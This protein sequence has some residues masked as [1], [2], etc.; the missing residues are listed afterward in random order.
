MNSFIKT[1]GK[2]W[3]DGQYLE[4]EDANIPVLTHGLHYA[5]CVYEGERSYR[6]KVF[7]IK[8]HIA[9]LFK[10]AEIMDMEIPYTSEELEIATKEVIAT[11]QLEDA[12][13]RPVVWR[14]SDSIA[15]FA[16]DN[17]IHTAICAWQW[18]SYYTKEKKLEGIRMCV[19]NWRRPDPQSA[20]IEAKASG[21]YM[22]LTLSKH[23][24]MRKGFDDALLLDLNGAVAEASSANIFFCS[25]NELHTPK[26]DNILNG[27]TRQTV[28]ELAAKRQ[29]KIVEREILLEEI[30]SFSEAFITGTACE[31]T[32][33]RELDGHVF[34]GS[35]VTRVIIDDYTALCYGTED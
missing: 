1:V 15:T 31:V 28:F 2:V 7:K 23:E 13:V 26:T 29:L 27:I 25:G 33:V 3:F 35:D 30:S 20:P 24:A 5:S 14:G 21:H 8:E 10:S 4:A 34:T 6:G 9:R 19:A 22:I 17:K 32:A 16:P 12:Y 18:P 11:N